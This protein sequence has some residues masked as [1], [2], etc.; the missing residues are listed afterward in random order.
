MQLYIPQAH[1]ATGTPFGELSEDP[2]L[3]ASVQR[4]FAEALAAS[5]RADA[6]L[7]GLAF[8]RRMMAS[9]A[10]RKRRGA[11]LAQ[12]YRRMRGD[13]GWSVRRTIDTLAEALRVECTGQTYERPRGNLWTPGDLLQ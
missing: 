12:L 2:A 5:F 11:L 13:W 9:E 8:A 10:E 1:Q 3:M 7:Y 4:A 6:A